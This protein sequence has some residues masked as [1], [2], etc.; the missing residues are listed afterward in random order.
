LSE[1]LDALFRTAL[2]LCAGHTADAEDLLQDA[3]LRALEHQDQLRDPAAGRSWLFTILV[4]THLNQ[5]RTERRRAEVT[6]SDLDDQ[7][8]ET[9]LAEWTPLRM[10]DE[11]VDTWR[12]GEQL[13]DALNTLP[14]A[15]RATVWLVDVEGF[16]QREVAAMHEVPEGTVASRLF[17]AR[18]QLR[19][20]L[21]PGQRQAAAP[22]GRAGRPT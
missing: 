3:T 12:L 6:A 5:R 13:T 9:A 4:R 18:R 10:P 20:V 1:H 17:R 21:E 8:F 11:L 19:T 7:A 2:R 16:T 14:E 22:Q 15:L